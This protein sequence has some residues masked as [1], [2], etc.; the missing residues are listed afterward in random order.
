MRLGA[1]DSLKSSAPML[2]PEDLMRVGLYVE[3][4]VELKEMP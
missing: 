2:F 3:C 4:L 1:D